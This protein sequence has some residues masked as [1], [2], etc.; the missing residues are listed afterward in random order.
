MLPTVIT[1]VIVMGV[2][3][4]PHHYRAQKGSTVNADLSGQ[5]NLSMKR[6]FV[7]ASLHGD[8]NDITLAPWIQALRD[9]VDIIGHRNM[10]L[11][12]YEDGPAPFSD[13]ALEYFSAIVKCEWYGS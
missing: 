1:I 7:A 11:S 12:I 13:P 9:L 6:I 5:R 10:F 2:I 4:L 8:E 3:F